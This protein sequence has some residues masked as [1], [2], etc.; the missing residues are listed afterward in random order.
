MPEPAAPI[1][2]TTAKQPKPTPQPT[3]FTI[4]F[5][6]TVLSK[7]LFNPFLAWILVLC[8]R[9]HVTPQSDPAWIATVSY[10]CVLTVVFIA[11]GINERVAHGTP[12]TV[13]DREVVLVTG[14]ASGLGLLIAQIYAMRGTRV[15]V[16][17]IKEIDEDV[18]EVF[19]DDVLYIA[20]DVGDRGA[21]EGAKEKISETLGMPTII[22]NC[23]AARINGLP[24]LEL[25]AG[26]F[27]KT[28]STNLL[29]AFHLFQVFLPG[30]IAAENG[31][32]L[33]TVSSVLGHLT[34]AGLSDYAA[35]KAG[36]SALHRTIEAELRG[37]PVKTLL[38]EVGQMT[39]PLFDWVQ[40]PNN[41]F[42]PVLEPVQVA[43]EMVAAIDSGRGGVIRLP[44]YAKLVNWYAVLP[45]AV[46]R[47]ARHLSGI[48]AA[49][50]Q[51]RQA[52]QK[53]D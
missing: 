4:D 7:S 36:L 41:F 49:V 50:T 25:S 11:R 12:R 43:R 44:A 48:D 51:S 53:L 19:G 15:A 35:S 34:A 27:E 13:D 45:A 38:V 5:I 24:L 30:T 9:A 47:V 14:G 18:S 28:I 22:I 10:A 1:I 37:S 33:V 26:A 16:L 8:L 20:C 52:S 40:A 17:D 3:R 32:T 23:A 31:G 39:T 2:K 42:A 29:A 6:L 21:L 46:Q